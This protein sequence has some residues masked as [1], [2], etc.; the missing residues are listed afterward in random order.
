MRTW[1]LALPNVIIHVYS[2]RLANYVA[3]SALDHGQVKNQ[4]LKVFILMGQSNM[5][6]FGNVAGKQNGTV[7]YAVEEKG[8]Y[9]FLRDAEGKWVTRDDVR[10]VFALGSGFRVRKNQWMS[11]ADSRGRLGGRIG[12][13]IGIGFAM[14][15][16]YEEPVLILKAC[17]G[18]RALGWDLLP[19]GSEGFELEDG[20]TTWV[21]PGYKGSPE[22]WKKGETPKPIGWYAG[23]Q[24]DTDTGNA[25]RILG[26]LGNYGFSKDTEYEV[27]GFFWWQGD[28]DSR[29]KAYS[30]R[31][32]TNLKQ[33]IK[34][35][36]VEF[37]APD[38]K[39]VTASLGQT[40][41]GSKGGDGQILDA[42]ESVAK[43]DPDVAAVYT[44]PLSLGS[45]S[46]GHYGKNGETYMNVGVA[47]GEAM[48][49]LLKGSSP[50]PPDCD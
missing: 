30:S 10:D 42:M 48:L 38:A 1:L 47:M 15:D 26:D 34:M 43:S 14:G 17:I 7:E 33:L 45:S 20:G 6:G 41:R 46:G 11:L 21:Y 3:A 39:F 24:W 37:N 8:M 27:E 18:N 4:K 32:E 44:N 23:K 22:K 5:L 28:R 12:P 35:L 29:S 2:S 25:K 36:K 9:K 19:P 16:Y 50:S 40:K 49:N 31:Y 13:E